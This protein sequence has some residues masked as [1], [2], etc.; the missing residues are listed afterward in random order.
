MTW[1]QQIK[2]KQ[3]QLQIELNKIKGLRTRTIEFDDDWSSIRCIKEL[4]HAIVIDR[5]NEIYN[6]ATDNILSEN[7]K[8]YKELQELSKLHNE[9]E[10][11]YFTY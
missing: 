5:M 2:I 7:H 11:K 8:D 4:E 1:K 6:N 10:S 3:L 9:Y